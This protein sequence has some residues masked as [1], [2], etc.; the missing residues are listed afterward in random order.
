MTKFYNL[1]FVMNYIRYKPCQIFSVCFMQE[2]TP[3]DVF[4]EETS[5]TNDDATPM[6]DMPSTSNDE[7]QNM[8]T[9]TKNQN[10]SRDQPTILQLLEG[11]KATHRLLDQS[12]T[13]QIRSSCCHGE[14]KGIRKFLETADY[15]LIDVYCRF[16][17]PFSFT[18]YNIIYWYMFTLT[19]HKTSGSLT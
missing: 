10:M 1:T 15:R 7:R 2:D 19:V 6:N 18:L 13:F 17:F 8:L 14:V 9:S 12:K 16:L 4:M 3:D 5:M 11:T